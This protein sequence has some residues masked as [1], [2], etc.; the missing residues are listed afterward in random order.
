MGGGAS[1]PYD[2]AGIPGM[3]MSGGTFSNPMNFQPM[4]SA[5]FGTAPNLKFPTFN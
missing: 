2:P 1:S 5:S 4:G 3:N